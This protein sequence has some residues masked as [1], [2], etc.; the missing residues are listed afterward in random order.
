[1]GCHADAELQMHDAAELRFGRF[2]VRRR[3]RRLLVD[4][5]PIELGARAI[6]VLLALIDADGA[7]ISKDELM[8]RVWPGVEV[9]EHNLTVQI[10]ALRKAL[11]PDRDLIRTVARHGY[12]FTGEVEALGATASPDRDTRD[13]APGQRA[14]SNISPGIQAL[15]GRDNELQELLE[16]QPHCRLLTLT[17]AGGIGK[18]ALAIEVARK[19]FVGFEGDT[20]LV[21]LAPLS[22]PSLVSSTIAA[23]L[24]L[25]LVGDEMSGEA[26]ARAIGAKSVRL[27][28][29]NCEHLIDAVAAVAEALL[30]VCPNIS[31]L[32]TSREALRIDGERIYRVPALDVP[33]HDQQDP[34]KLLNNGAVQLFVARL[35][36]LDSHF[37]ATAENLPTIA[38]ICRR[39]DGIPLAIEL[40]VARAA[41]LGLHEVAAR[42]DDRF[43]LLTGGR[44]TALPRHQTL[45]A[46]LD[47]SHELLPELER[48]L[49]RRLAVFPAGFTIT[50]AIAVAQDTDRDPAAVVDGVTNLVAKSLLAFD[51]SS[52]DGHWRLLETVRA[53]ALEKLAGSGELDEIVRRHAGFFLDLVKAASPLLEA[54]A[55]AEDLSRLAL[56]IDNVRAAIDWAFSTTG[57]A[58][59]GSELIA[60]YVPVWMQLSLFGE[61]RTRVELAVAALDRGAEPSPRT[62][63]ML[64]AALGL[65]L[66][67]TRGPVDEAELNWRRVL[68]I[69]QDLADADY[70]LRALYGLWL[71]RILLC[72]CRPALLLAKQFLQVAERTTNATDLATAD[73]MLAVVLHYV[74][75]QEGASA[76]AERSLAGPVPVNRHVY[77]T[78][79]AVD[80]RV[81]ALV[82]LARSLWLR[83][84]PDQAMAAARDSVDE[85]DAVGH[86]NSLCLALADGASVIAVLTGDIAA[87]ERFQ[88]MLSEHADNHTLGVWRIYARALQGRLRLRRGSAAAAVALLKSALHELQETP[89][90]IRSQTYLVWLAEALGAAGQPDEGL[91]VIDQALERAELTGERWSVAEKL[92]LR[93]E[94]LLQADPA[95]AGSEARECFARS[96][97]TA[98]E[99]AALGW[100]LRTTISLVRGFRSELDQR[101]AF[102]MLNTVLSRFGEGFSTGDLIAA[103]SLLSELC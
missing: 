81:G 3:Q 19:L 96:L 64:R 16:L 76:C 9:E 25:R 7:L 30:R 89:L 50:S 36:A 66:S 98:R 5:D 85:A 52:P 56:Q 80:Q 65:S 39:L 91:L 44:R 69:A 103:R 57:N 17:G 6:D 46:T 20:L 74:G 1:M 28:L 34:G 95:G 12:C 43:G 58:V 38:A 51:G 33:P 99:Q 37:A 45:R 48:S 2:Q 87:G 83:G 54:D 27:V 35:R 77:T 29:D 4:G 84:F 21:E 14:L 90:D 75:D 79:Y 100:E 101:E 18:T 70:Q 32:A 40:A 67:Y 26:V 59:V 31:I 15:I 41:T 23:V 94:L 60:A 86:I 78:R 42:L 72:D 47:W 62:E 71:Y 11:G 10:H 61:C 93:G 63:M 22:D 53:Y 55:A 73:R 97:A 88:A 82:M 92:R 24:G 13:A 102:A 49:L 68:R 8:S